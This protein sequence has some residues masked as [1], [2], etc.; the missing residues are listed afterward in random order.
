MAVAFYIPDQAAMLRK[1][2]EQ[3]KQLLRLRQW[4]MATV[5]LNT[6]RQLMDSTAG[7]CLQRAGRKCGKWR[8]P[9]Q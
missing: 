3:E 2:R 1:A 6:I 9:S 4:Q 8:K 5:M 7:Q